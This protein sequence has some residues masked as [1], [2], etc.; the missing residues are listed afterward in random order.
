MGLWDSIVQNLRVDSWGVTP[1]SLVAPLG[2]VTLIMM[3]GRLARAKGPKLESGSLT[4][5]ALIAVIIGAA[6]CWIL[7]GLGF[8]QRSFH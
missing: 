5:L 7:A 6:F 1:A 4:G 8:L 2:L 3:A